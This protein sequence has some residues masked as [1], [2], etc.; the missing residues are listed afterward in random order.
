MASAQLDPGTQTIF[1]GTGQ[2]ACGRYIAR[3]PAS[4]TTPHPAAVQALLTDLYHAPVVVERWD[5]L[6]PWAVARALL[7]G[8]GTGRTVIVKWVR[9]GVAEVRTERWRL[10]TE[11]AA[12]RFLSDD[13]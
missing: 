6:E 13:L 9:A 5:R 7:S 4:A 11:L 8:S 2:R 10:G 3:M 1:N 12:L